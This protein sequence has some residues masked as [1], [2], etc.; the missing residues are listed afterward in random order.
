MSYQETLICAATW[1]DDGIEYPQQPTG[2]TTGRVFMGLNH[3]MIYQLVGHSV[4]ERIEMGL[5]EKEQ[6]FV[7]SLAR[8]V[9]RKEALRIATEAEQIVVKHGSGSILFSEDIINWDEIIKYREGQKNE[10]F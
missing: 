9:D 2:I 7:T 4:K 6:G 1:F 5:I 3:A 10:N 8:F